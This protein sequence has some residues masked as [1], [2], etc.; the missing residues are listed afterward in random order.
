MLNNPE[1]SIMLID[2]RGYYGKKNYEDLSGRSA[3]GHP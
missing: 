3:G 2:W 1:H